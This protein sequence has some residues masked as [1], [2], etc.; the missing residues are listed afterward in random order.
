[1]SSAGSSREACRLE[2]AGSGINTIVER[3]GAFP[4]VTALLLLLMAALSWTAARGDSL[5][6]DE[7]AHFPHGYAYWRTG[8]MWYDEVH[9]ALPRLLT[10]APLL[11][12]DPRTPTEHHSWATYD[13][14]A[15]RHIFLFRNRVRPDTL[16]LLARLPSLLAALLLGLALALWTRAHFGALPGLLALFLYALHPQVLAFSHYATSDIFVTAA[17]FAAA[18]AW[19]RH[20]EDRRLHT[21]VLAGVAAGLAL[22]TKYSMILLGAVFPTLY[23]WRW[24]QQPKRYSAGGLAIALLVVGAC[25]VLTVGA[26]YWPVT[27]EVLWGGRVP[28][29]ERVDPSTP[30]GRVFQDVAA[31]L[32]L[33]AH[34]YLMGFYWIAKTNESGT[35]AYLLGA[36]ANRGWWHYFPVAFLVKSPLAFLA[37]VAISLGAVGGWLLGARQY[38]EWRRLPLAWATLAVP[39]VVYLGAA[40]GASLNSGSRHLLPLLP[41]LCAFAGA[42]V[43][44]P[45]ASAA[46]LRWRTAAVALLAA[47]FAAESAS[48]YPGYLAYFNGIAGGTRRGSE[49]LVDSDLDWGQDLLRLRDY[50]DQSRPERVCLA[51]F[52][53]ADPAYYGIRSR[54]LPPQL[55]AGQPPPDCLAVVSET[56]LA[57]LYVAPGDFGWLKQHT[58]AGNVG[59]SFR[60][61]D[62][63][64]CRTNNP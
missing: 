51:Y 15:F 29:V 50:L 54:W 9:A 20:L 45:L 48:A 63:R 57:G 59:A 7:S 23:C 41:F 56:Y 62:F 55:P 38:M 13:F 3:R 46:L 28:M 6:W 27:G 42:A 30:T 10:G 49:Y 39:A 17:F 26:V 52:G 21:L 44:A 14:L 32:R 61:Y 22:S 4:A 35:P 33:P 8:N 53:A 25:A 58:P 11:L 24:W 12:A 5:V 2:A 47:G 64:R 18:T 60:L 40:L 1:M 16:T 43:G 34:P 31:H 37:V 19:S 36:V